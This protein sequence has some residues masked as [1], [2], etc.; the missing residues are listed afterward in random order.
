MIST[1]MPVMKRL[2]LLLLLGL[3]PGMM[4]A[5]KPKAPPPAPVA[6]AAPVV[7]PEAWRATPPAPLPEGDWAPPVAKTF[8]L[9][10]GIPVYFVENPA[11]PLAS[12]RLV[13]TVGREA[14]P[15][16]KA[17]LGAL[18]ANLL[19]EGT[20]SRDS[21]AIASTAGSLGANLS[22]GAGEE[23]ASVSLDALTGAPLGPSLD[24][25]ADVALNPRFDAKDFARVQ[26]ETI[27]SIQS[28]KADPRE[29]AS[30]VFAAQLYGAGHPYGIPAIG[31]EATVASIKSGDVKKFYQ[32]W[33]HAG[34]AAF[35]VTGKVDEAG[36]KAELEKRFGVWKVGKSVH[37]VPAAASVPLKTRLVFVEQP[38]AVQSVIRVGTP[39]PKRTAPDFQAANVAGTI[40]GGMFSSRLNINLRE[41]HGWSYGA[42]GGFTESRDA[43]VFAART[44]VQA[45]KT[46]P[47]VVEILK[48]LTAAAAKPPSDKELGLAKDSL[49]KSLPGNFETNAATAGSFLAVPVMGLGPDYWAGWLTDLHK[50]DAAASEA[51]AKRYFD[52]AKMLIVVAGPRTITV[53]G[54]TVDVVAELKA[55]GYDFV[56]VK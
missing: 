16:G 51:Q 7:D 27:T 23:W 14:N 9:S 52:A 49:I 25:F 24:L 29:V 33:W 19:D 18:T 22:V 32:T 26:A 41:E 37:P 11:L 3:V 1:V 21:A 56:E 54:T 48:E 30:R 50:V 55:L 39:G 20:K 40:V 53:D 8:K 28:A 12:V 6:V 47:A 45:D 13:M 5:K 4:A 42:Y 2:S 44:S 43:G 46:A 31:D 38:G 15:A 34:N 36:L 35:V 17:G 10:N